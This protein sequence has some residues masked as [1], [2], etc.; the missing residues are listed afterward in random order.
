MSNHERKQVR[1]AD[2]SDITW[3]LSSALPLKIGLEQREGRHQPNTSRLLLSGM[4]TR[5][6]GERDFVFRLLTRAVTQNQTG[7]PPPR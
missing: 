5:A 1:A 4:V 2:T 7:C 3:P 6:A